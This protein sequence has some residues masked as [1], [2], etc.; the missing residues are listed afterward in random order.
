M[1]P[2]TE[3]LKERYLFNIAFNLGKKKNQK[4]SSN[5]LSLYY[6]LRK[7]DINKLTQGD[8]PKVAFIVGL[9]VDKKA[10]RRNLIK[11]RMR[12]AYRLVSRKIN[13]R[14]SKNTLQ[15]LIWV[16]N[17]GIKNATFEQIKSSMENLLSKLERSSKN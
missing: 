5:L 12:S 15:A 16:A 13:I 10:A 9:G 7:K 2:K 11:R 6:L 1:L 17:Q 3:R 14:Q 4:V 8:F